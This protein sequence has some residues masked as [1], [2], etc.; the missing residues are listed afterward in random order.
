MP[1]PVALQLYSVRDYMEEGFEATVRRVAEIG[2]VGVEPA[3]FPGTTS[4]KAG[5][6]FADLGLEVPSAHVQLPLGD[7]EDDVIS[8]MK[9]IGS[10]TI[11]SG[12][13]PDDFSTPARIKETCELF[14]EANRI[15]RSH[16]MTFGL[17]NHWWEYTQVEGRYV[18]EA[19]LEYLDP[20]IQFEIDTYWVQTAGVDPVEI[21]ETF[22]ERAPL[23]HIKD[24]SCVK[25]EPMTAVGDGVLDIPAIVAAGKPVTEWLIVELDRCATDMME[26]VTRSYEYLVGEGLA[27]GR[28]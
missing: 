1:A 26:A 19:M 25:E 13:G 24:G 10:S 28:S 9:A 2:Y 4:E 17:H 27:R 5:Q 7:Q 18:Y 16:G 3:G 21:V 23:L 14:N 12:K 20:T 6:L 15:A 11:V 8:T 22:G